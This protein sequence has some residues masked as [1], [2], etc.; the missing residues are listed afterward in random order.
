[1]CTDAGYPYL[2][3][4]LPV[5]GAFVAWVVGQ[6]LRFAATVG[7]REVEVVVA[8]AVACEDDLAPAGGEGWLGVVGPLCRGQ[9]NLVGPVCLGHED[10][11]LEPVGRTMEGDTRIV[12]GPVGG[13]AFGDGLPA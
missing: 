10:P 5:G 9:R 11:R 3:D 4:R 2:S 12:G 6:P 7:F 13:V 1:M 8:V